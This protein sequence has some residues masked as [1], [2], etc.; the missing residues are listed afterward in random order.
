MKHDHT[1]D[2]AAEW[3]A[4]YAAGALTSAENLDFEAHLRAACPACREALEQL[5]PVMS[6]LAA[7]IPLATPDPRIRAALLERIGKQR[8][9]GP[10]ASPLKR[11]LE[12][13]AANAPLDLIIQRAAAA[14]WKDSDVPGVRV[15][16]LS[17]DPSRNQFTALV[18]MAPGTSYPPHIHGGPEECLVLEG[19]LHVGE[20][21][22]GPGDYQRAPTGSRHGTQSTQQGCLLLIVSSLTDAFI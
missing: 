3:A 21:V 11:Q 7:G 10:K 5:A 6:V 14:P 4:L 2:E 1:V 18:R 17:T 8:A 20:E 22:M 13:D 9:A 16:V 19:D 15:R 12:S